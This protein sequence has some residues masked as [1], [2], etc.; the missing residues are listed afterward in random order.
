MH[1]GVVPPSPQRLLRTPAPRPGESFPGY[2]LRLAEENSYDSLRW[3]PERAGLMVDPA[4][5]QWA[6]LWSSGPHITLLCEMTGLSQVE[7]ASLRETLAPDYLVRWKTPKICPLCLREE[8]W[9]RKAWDVLPF[10]VCPLHRIVL[11]DFCPHCTHP[12]SWTR[13]S[14]NV[15]RCGYDWRRVSRPVIDG[16]GGLTAARRMVS[17]WR[18]K[19]HATSRPKGATGRPPT[20]EES[21]AYCGSAVPAL[22][23]AWLFLRNQVRLRPTTRK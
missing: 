10:T 6:Q 1:T 4:R 12:I 8:T 15:C 22:A 2:L 14:I 20:R 11:V 7:L 18:E 9:C 13:A 21:A 17:I 5:G 19:A 23:D 16:D 3:I